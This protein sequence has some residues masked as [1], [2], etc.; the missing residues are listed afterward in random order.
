M[1]TLFING[2]AKASRI[3]DREADGIIDLIMLVFES[4]D[5]KFIGQLIEGIPFVN[6][7]DISR[8]EYTQAKRDRD[9]IWHRVIFA[10]VKSCLDAF[11]HEVTQ[12]SNLNFQQV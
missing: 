1:Q 8:N 9:Q 6:G 11:T 7:N 4:F 3:K 12:D 5:D 2:Q 10:A